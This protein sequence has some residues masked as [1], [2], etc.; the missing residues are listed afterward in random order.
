MYHS[1][2]AGLGLLQPFEA[3]LLQK[4]I[5]KQFEKTV[6]VAATRTG[7]FFTVPGTRVVVR[8]YGEWRTFFAI[9]IPA[10]LR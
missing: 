3:L 9:F 2:L 1:Y 5:C 6:A 4:P 7:R 8:A 10:H